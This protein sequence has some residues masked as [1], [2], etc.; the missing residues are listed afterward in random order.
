V[1]VDSY[2]D[3]GPGPR[4]SQEQ[5]MFAYEYSKCMSCRLLPGGLSSIPE[6]GVAQSSPTRP[7]AVPR[8]MREAVDHS[9]IGAHAIAQVDLST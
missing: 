4:Q 3:M 7:R 1:P 5:Q 8:A 2:Y 9:F 6:D